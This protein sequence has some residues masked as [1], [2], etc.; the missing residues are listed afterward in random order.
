MDI[1]DNEVLETDREYERPSNRQS[2]RVIIPEF[3]QDDE[4]NKL[5]KLL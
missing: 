3:D 5:K 2:P 4:E 1:F